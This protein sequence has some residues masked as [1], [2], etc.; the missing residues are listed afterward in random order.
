LIAGG[1]VWV[2]QPT[3]R[4]WWERVIY[5]APVALAAA[6]ASAPSAKATELQKQIDELK[7]P[8]A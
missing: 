5:A 6:G 2:A 3:G 4:P 8:K 7:G 1:G